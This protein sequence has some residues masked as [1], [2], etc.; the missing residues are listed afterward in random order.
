M[1][2]TDRNLSKNRKAKSFGDVHGEPVK[3]HTSNAAA[4]LSALTSLS[5]PNTTPDVCWCF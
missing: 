3:H 5:Q 2:Y 4:L 1:E